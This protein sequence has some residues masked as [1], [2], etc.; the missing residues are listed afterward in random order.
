MNKKK[1]RVINDSLLGIIVPKTDTT[2]SKSQFYNFTYMA[3]Q[4]MKKI[5]EMMIEYFCYPSN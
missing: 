5:D 2:H 1:Q 4:I 3:T